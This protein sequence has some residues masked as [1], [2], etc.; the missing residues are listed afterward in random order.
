MC[1]RIFRTLELE[2]VFLQNQSLETL[3][4]HNYAVAVVLS[5][6]TI[7]GHLPRNKSTLCHIFLLRN[8]DILIVVQ[9]SGNNAYVIDFVDLFFAS[10]AFN[11]EIREN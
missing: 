6:N 9:I 7:V 10:V 11:C 1:L 4:I 3:T 8:G 2:I 5:N